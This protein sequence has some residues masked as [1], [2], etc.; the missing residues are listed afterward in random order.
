[1]FLESLLLSRQRIEDRV[2]LFEHA[3]VSGLHALFFDSR[4]GFRLVA[5]IARPILSSFE[6]ARA[7]LSVVQVVVSVMMHVNYIDL[8]G[9]VSFG[10]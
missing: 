9:Q 4:R 8:P 6:W 3:A 2:H 5:N 7:R 10:C 1:M